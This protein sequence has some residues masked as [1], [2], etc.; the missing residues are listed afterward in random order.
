MPQLRPFA[1]LFSLGL[2]AACTTPPTQYLLA[3]EA[4][5]PQFRSRLASVEVRDISLP[6]YATADSIA[7]M[8]ET[9]AMISDPNSVWADDPQRALTQGLAR[10]LHQIT[11]ARVAAEPWPFAGPPSATLSVVVDQIYASD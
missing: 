6:R 7:L 8:D 2:L 9:G 5:A 10:Q 3:P 1:L 11:G 4:S